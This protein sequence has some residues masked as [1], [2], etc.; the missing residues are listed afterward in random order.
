MTDLLQFAKIQLTASL[1]REKL[2]AYPKLK[3]I[4]GIFPVIENSANAWKSIVEIFEYDMTGIATILAGGAS[5][6]G[7]I[8]VFARKMFYNIRSISAYTEVPWTEIRQAEANQ[9]GISDKYSQA[10]VYGHRLKLNDI[11]FN[12]DVANG[13]QGIFTSQIERINAASTFAAA[14]SPEAMIAIIASAISAVVDNSNGLWQPKKIVLPEK[15]YQMLATTYRA[16][17]EQT[18]LTAVLDAQRPLGGVEEFIMDNT[19]KGKGDSGTDCM[20]ILPDGISSFDLTNTEDGYTLNGEEQNLP[21]YF[22]L[23]LDTYVPAEWIQF[24]DTLVRE[25]GICRTGGLVVTDPFS[26]AI[27]SGI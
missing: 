20:L 16:Y 27:V 4:G 14:A 10:L 15:Q 9:I 12:G 17:T 18:V 21:M 13:L 22:S 23:P 11:A 6:G 8:D 24:L 2:R 5:D 26:G 1:V 3:G 7:K 19:L 25:R